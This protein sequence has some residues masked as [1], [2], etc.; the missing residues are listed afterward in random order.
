MRGETQLYTFLLIPL[1]STICP[2]RMK[3][4]TAT[5]EY[6]W[7]PFH[8]ALPIMDWDPFAKKQ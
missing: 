5:S 7:T 2:I 3:Q 1:R 6:I 4:D 8:A